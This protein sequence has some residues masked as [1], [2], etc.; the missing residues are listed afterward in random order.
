MITLIVR[1]VMAVDSIAKSLDLL[2]KRSSYE[3]PIYYVDKTKIDG[4]R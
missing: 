3:Y 2:S 4:S 1:F